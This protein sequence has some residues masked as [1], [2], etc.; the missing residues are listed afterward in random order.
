MFDHYPSTL[1]KKASETFGSALVMT[2][3][4]G[5]EAALML[6]IVTKVVPGIRVVTVDT[7]YLFPETHEFM[8]QLQMQFDFR[9]I[10]CRAEE[11]PQDM[12]KRLGKL[13]EQGTEG[14]QL[15]N[16]LRK[17]EPMQKELHELGAKAWL[18]GIRAYQ[19]PARSRKKMV[20]V[21]LD[22]ITRV[23]PILRWTPIE[24]AS[25]F[26]LHNLPFH[27]LFEK[28]YASIGDVHSTKPGNGRN[29]RSLGP[30]SECGLHMMETVPA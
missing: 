28:G 19:T 8:C 10:L 11:S 22:G 29:G 25:Y 9:L 20:E 26:A 6:D 21:G 1:I 18:S 16:R 23:Y 3:S 27:P 5:A 14:V 17:V 12:E 7:G 24:V 2:S 30:Q 15:Y 13:W 4:F